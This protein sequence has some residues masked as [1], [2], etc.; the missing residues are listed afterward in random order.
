MDEFELSEKCRQGD[1]LA[2]K[3]LYERY[4][5]RMLVVCLRYAGD[6][7]RAQD[8]LHD[9]FLKIYSSFEKFTWRGEGSLRA[10]M[11]RVVVNICLEHLR[12]RDVLSQA[13]DI[14]NYQEGYQEPDAGEVERIPHHILMKLIGELP[15]GYRM[16]FNLFV[17]E[18]KSHREIAQQL[19][20]NEKSSSSQLFRAKTQL[21]KRI[22]EYIDKHV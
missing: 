22:K 11:E 10:W 14:D 20:I 21:A 16:V 4:A 13:A 5:G 6:R 1:N 18:Q 3:V 19:G 9:G 12:Q 17:F 8:M 2:R 7:D 15:E